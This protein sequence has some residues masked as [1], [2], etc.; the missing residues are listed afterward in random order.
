E[1]LRKAGLGNPI[2][3]AACASGGGDWIASGELNHGTELVR[4]AVPK[5]QRIALVDRSRWRAAV[6]SE[7]ATHFPIRQ[8]LFHRPTPRFWRGDR[9][10]GVDAECVRNIKV[11][12]AMERL[13]QPP[14][15]RIDSVSEGIAGDRLR[16]VVQRFRER[17]GDLELK[18]MSKPLL[19]VHVQPV[20]VGA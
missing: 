2:W 6:I 16:S 5:A 9:V 13:R 10:Q 20:V 11:G 15:R 12:W 3:L 4:A 17:I 14:P 8:S 18:I 7:N 19:Q 1:R